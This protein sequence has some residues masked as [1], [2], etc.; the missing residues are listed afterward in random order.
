MVFDRL[1]P[2]LAL[3]RARCAACG[4]PISPGDREMRLHGEHYHYDC[5]F[6]RSRAGRDD[7]GSG[8]DGRDGNGSGPDGRP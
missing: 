1:N 8:P 2:W 3:T 4:K 6:Y 5:T 7:D